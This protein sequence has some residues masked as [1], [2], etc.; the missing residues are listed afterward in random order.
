MS[1]KDDI[2]QGTITGGSKRKLNRDIF[3]FAF[4]LVLSFA[5][6][7]LNSLSKDLEADIRYPLVI[8]NIPKDKVPENAIP[9]RLNLVFA[10]PGYS[11]LKQKLT[12]V[13]DPLI[14]DF[15]KNAVRASRNGKNQKYYIATS[16]LIKN[17]NNQLKSDCKIVSLKPD[18]IF[19][20]FK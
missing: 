4:F 11:I 5:F 17:F 8:N 12:G 3:A 10:G 19:I 13:N 16:G 14:I 9:E 18:T 20:T 7:Y 2:Q 15:Q 1:R 6:W